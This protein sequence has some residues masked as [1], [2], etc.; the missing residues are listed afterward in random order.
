MNLAGRRHQLFMSHL[1]ARRTA[2]VTG[3]RQSSGRATPSDWP[4]RGAVASWRVLTELAE[5]LDPPERV[6]GSALVAP[7]GPG[8]GTVRRIATHPLDLRRPQ[9]DMSGM[10]WA[11]A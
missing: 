8:S 10:S 2:L 7:G 9:E 6:S 1:F 5:T 11:P 3:D 4:E